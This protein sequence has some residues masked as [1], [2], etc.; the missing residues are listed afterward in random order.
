M[1]IKEK[2]M[3]AITDDVPVCHVL[4]QPVGEVDI[5]DEGSLKS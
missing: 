5:E 2:E 4:E 1:P 3:E